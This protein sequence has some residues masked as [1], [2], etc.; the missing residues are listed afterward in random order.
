MLLMLRDKPL[1]HH[2]GLLKLS[3]EGNE[4]AREDL[5]PDFPVG[6]EDEDMDWEVL[7]DQ[8]DAQSTTGQNNS[9]CSF[10]VPSTP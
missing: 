5:W 6:W 10:V 7:K 2:N 8:A 1:Y 3:E 9:G 4:R